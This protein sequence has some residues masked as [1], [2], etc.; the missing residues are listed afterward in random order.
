MRSPAANWTGFGG[1]LKTDP[2]RA[3]IDFSIV[4]GAITSPAALVSASKS[5]TVWGNWVA[6][7]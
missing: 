2:F 6:L 1:E 4:S 5:G 3:Q 7:S